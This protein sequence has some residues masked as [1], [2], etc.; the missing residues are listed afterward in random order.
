MLCDV[1]PFLPV[2]KSQINN[3]KECEVI[4]EDIERMQVVKNKQWYCIIEII[5]KFKYLIPARTVQL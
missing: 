1:A 5:V 3:S 4:Q 2:R